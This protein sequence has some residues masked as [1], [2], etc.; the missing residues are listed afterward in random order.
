MATDMVNR[1]LQAFFRDLRTFRAEP[2]GGEPAQ[3]GDLFSGVAHLSPAERE[4]LLERIRA[5]LVE[6]DVPAPGRTERWEY[7][8][9]AHRVGVRE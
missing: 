8:L 3:F 9:M 5:F 6:H 2:G 7:V 4:E 1:I